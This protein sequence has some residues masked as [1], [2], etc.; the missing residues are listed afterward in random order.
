MASR[1]ENQKLVGS[2]KYLSKI[3]VYSSYK[4]PEKKEAYRDVNTYLSIF[5]RIV[6][7][8]VQKG[9]IKMMTFLGDGVKARDVFDQKIGLTI[10]E[11]A[12][13]HAVLFTLKFF[14]RRIR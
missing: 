2:L 10:V 14:D 4:C 8:L 12:R 13:V 6:C 9:G 11:A 7:L 1:G 3:D 5:S